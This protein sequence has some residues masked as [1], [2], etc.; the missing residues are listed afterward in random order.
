MSRQLPAAVIKSNHGYLPTKPGLQTGF[1]LAG[2]GVK[3]GVVLESVRLVDVAPTIA[4]LLGLN[5]K[6]T[7]GHALKEVLQ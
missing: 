2:R 6:D 4:E 1:L 3:K 7:D 5:M